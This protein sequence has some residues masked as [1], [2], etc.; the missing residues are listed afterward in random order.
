MNAI[1]LSG[2]VLWAP[3]TNPPPYY[4]VK[5]YETNVL[6]FIAYPKTN[7]V[8]MEELMHHAQPG[9]YR[10]E[11]EGVTTNYFYHLFPDPPQNVKVED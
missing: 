10:M 1:V 8:V 5:V 3:L 11:I 6:K 9:Y 2:F 7:F 4:T